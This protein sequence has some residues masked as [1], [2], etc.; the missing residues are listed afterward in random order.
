[1]F[2]LQ[3]ILLYLSVCSVCLTFAQVENQF[4][5]HGFSG[6]NLYLSGASKVHPN[7]LLE[8]TNISDH[9]IG[10]T[11]FPFPFKFNKSLSKNFQSLSFSTNFAFAI[12]PKLP[13]LGGHGIAFT[14]SSSVEFPG[15]LATQYFGLFNS[16]SGNLSSNH[17]FAVELDTVKNIDVNDI[18]SNHVG[19][20]VNGLIS[21]ESIPVAYYSDKE[22]ENKSLELISGNPMQMWIDY[23][24]ED[25]L[26]NVT[27]APITSL[28]PEKPLLSTT[29]DLTLVLLDSMYVGFSS[30]TG[31]TTSYHYIL[32]W[33]FN[34]SGPAQ[35]LDISKLPSLPPRRESSKRTDL[36][37]IIPS[38][39]V[40]VVLIIISGIVYVLRRKKFEELREDWE[41]EYCPQ[42]FSY[43]DLYTATKGF[44][45]KELLGFGGFGGVYRGIL[46]S[47]NTEVAVK[48]VS[49]DS[50]QGMKEFVAEI[51]SMGRL[52]HRNLVQLLGYCRRKGELLLVY[53]YMPNGSLD[54]F[55][56]RS[57]TPNLNWVQR[58]QILRGVASALLY[59][60]EEWEQVVLHRDVK[61]SNVLL[62]ADL[63]GRLGDFGLARF[64]DH[65]SIPQTTSVAG[66]V[67]YLAPEV[68][69]T[70]MTTTSSDVFA[71]GTLMLEMACGRKPIAPERPPEEMILVDWVLE[72]WKRGVILE[73]SDPRL[74]GKFE[75]EKMELVLKLG[76]LC[77]HPTPAARPTLRQVMQ[78]LDRNA[79]LPDIPLDGPGIGLVTV[80][81]EVAGD[82]K[83]SFPTSN[84]YSGL[85]STD[86][87]LSYGR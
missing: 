47:S 69:R 61:A 23:D 34:K 46:P 56:F 5:Y 9:Q 10:R 33:S 43:R 14:I 39:T 44:R 86:S 79:T 59:L 78:Y 26:L 4:I 74:E 28:K 24:E 36:R 80:G 60:H 25:K 7:G 29:I 16:T 22:R 62:D 31:V 11:F 1:M 35:S 52:R 71:F 85:S 8:L 67:G 84:E 30:S 58:Y 20:D 76:L 41:Q 83:L 64:Y 87:I 45:E 66:T 2:N 3:H 15:A 49:H 17:V 57:D 38:I 12:V 63:N 72:C 68:T 50:K 73:T 6:A 40:S 55:L 37:I 18:D 75:V 51:V 19:I 82:C 21:K 54:K 65:G 48:K 70:G 27:V 42:R 77:A 32:G 81:Q 53:D 13:A